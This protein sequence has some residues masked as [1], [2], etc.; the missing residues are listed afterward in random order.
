MVNQNQ[1]DY[2][3]REVIYVQGLHCQAIG[4]DKMNFGA[5]ATVAIVRMVKE[6]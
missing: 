2:L 3:S 4:R 5:I 1:D 6:L